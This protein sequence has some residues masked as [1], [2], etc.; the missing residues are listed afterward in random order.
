MFYL[1]KVF[2]RWWLW[3]KGKKENYENR[4]RNLKKKEISLKMSFGS[5]STNQKQLPDGAD[6]DEDDTFRIM[7]V[8]KKFD[9][10]WPIL[11]EVFLIHFRKLLSLPLT[12]KF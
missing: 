5:I 4:A 8:S 2:S 11:L 3:E 10:K 6:L 7:L 12:Q 1:L 9:R